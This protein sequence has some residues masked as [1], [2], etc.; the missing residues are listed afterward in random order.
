MAAIL[1][2]S[3]GPPPTF[4]HCGGPSVHGP[5][6]L[7]PYLLYM[8]HNPYYQ[9]CFCRQWLNS[10]CM[11]ISVSGSTLNINVDFIKLFDCIYCIK[12][13]GSGWA[14]SAQTPWGVHEREGKRRIDGGREVAPGL[15]PQDLWQISATATYSTT[16]LF[17]IIVHNHQRRLSSARLPLRVATAGRKEHKRHV[18]ILTSP[19]VYTML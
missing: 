19:A 2:R 10:A 6:L 16:I 1:W 7:V 17:D 3:W 4:W 8:A 15:D 12:M 5:P 9:F 11:L 14:G 18:S 13:F